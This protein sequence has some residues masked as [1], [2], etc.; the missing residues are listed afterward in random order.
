MLVLVNGILLTAV[1]RQVDADVFGTVPSIV[2]LMKGEGECGC[3]ARDARGS[4]KGQIG[5]CGVSAPQDRAIQRRLLQA[6]CLIQTVQVS[7]VVVPLDV[8]ILHH[9]RDAC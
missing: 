3:P 1:R 6:R 5:S 2:D 4:G 9:Q 8:H 7:L